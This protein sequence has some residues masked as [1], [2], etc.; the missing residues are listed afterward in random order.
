MKFS[1]INQLPLYTDDFYFTYFNN[2]KVKDAIVIHNPQDSLITSP[3]F[4]RSRRTLDDH[5]EYVRKN[6]IR[7]AYIVAE[8]IFFLPQCSSIEYLKIFPAMNVK[9]FDYSPLYEMAS[10]KWLECRTTTGLTDDVVATVDYSRIKGIKQLCISHAGGHINVD[11]ADGVH[12]LY[13]QFGYPNARNLQN[14]IPGQELLSFAVCQ[15]PINSVN[16]IEVAHKLRR[17]LLAHNRKLTDISDLYYLSD[18]LVFLEIDTCG[19]ISDFSVL[20]KL[21]N[22]E[23]LILKGSNTLENLSFI[24]NMP[25]LKYLH[26]TMNI[27]NGD[28]SMCK[29]VAY[30]RIQNRK[31]YTHK[32]NDLPKNYVDP[33]EVYPFDIV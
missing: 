15:S 29:R 23:F 8:N 28:T 33:D 31:H 3:V 22:L 21:H 27:A 7:K 10:I 11:K 19:K 5:I 26:I 24:E 20:S 9:D 12:A 14:L 16:G 2:I 32:D 30:A 13:F 4:L 18:S 1:S 25:N 6:N 17:L